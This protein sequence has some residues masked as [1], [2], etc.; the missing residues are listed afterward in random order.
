MDDPVH[1]PLALRVRPLSRNRNF[2]LLWTGQVL[3][4]LGTQIG[5]LAYTLLVYALTRSAVI[6]GSV[7]TVVAVVAFAVRLPAG[8]LADRC[9]LRRSMIW[10]DA[11]RAVVL[12]GLA[13]GVVTH[14][15]T[16]PFVL[17]VAIVDR[18]GDT[19]F[20]PASVAALPRLVHDT[21]LE[22][23]WAATEARQ[24]AASLAGPSLGG[25]LYGIG[26]ST[27][28]VADA[29]S[30]GISAATSSA[31][32]G[33]FAPP[34]SDVP[35]EGLWKE[36]FAGVRVMVRDDLLR[37]VMIQAPLINFA[38][39]GV[40]FTVILGLRHH[41][42]SS[43]VIGLTESGVLVGGLL[44]AIVAPRLQGRFSLSALVVALTAGGAVLIAAAAVLIPSP[45]VAIPVA[46]PFFLAPTANAALFAVMLRRS[47]ESMRGRV[48]NALIQAATGLAAL[49]PLASGLL[50]EHTSPHWAMGAFAITLGVSAV[51]AL[52]LRS[53][54]DAE[55]AASGPTS[56][57]RP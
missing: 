40:L 36:A 21:Q 48:N 52:S 14:V 44:G 10:C 51:L 43:T 54:R 12:A 9:D 31:L 18:V 56:P 35:R 49:A 34:P 16:W 41:G 25:I 4:D 32:R 33:E 37:A 38:F 2:R 30:Y 55:A 3:S 15:V 6:A 39:T 11:V 47:P 45:L 46:I 57:E 29:V 28:F 50:V 19:F 24:Y 1:E 22:G 13:I 27:P 42:T 5:A 17:G 53:L 7:G 23:A 8:A 26:R 20:S